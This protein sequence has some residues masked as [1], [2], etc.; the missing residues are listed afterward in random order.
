MPRP[1]ALSPRMSKTRHVKVTTVQLQP[2][3][4][5]DISTKQTSLYPAN[6][7][8]VS[9]AIS[10]GVFPCNNHEFDGRTKLRRRSNPLHSESSSNPPW[11]RMMLPR[12]GTKFN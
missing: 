10:S 4:D 11:T 12:K 1:L 7:N 5:Q 3:S 6:A 2:L 8:Y 9:F